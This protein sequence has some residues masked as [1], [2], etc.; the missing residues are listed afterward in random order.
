MERNKHELEQYGA[1]QIQV[2][3]AWF[4]ALRPGIHQFGWLHHLIYEVVNNMWTVYGRLCDQIQLTLKPDSIVTI[5]DNGRGIPQKFIPKGVP[6]LRL[7]S[8]AFMQVVFGGG[9][10]S[11][12]GTPGVFCCKCARSGWKLW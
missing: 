4:Y 6:Q 1:E 7:S 8:H 2:L 9:G 3:E 12:R 5:K 10:Y 11:F